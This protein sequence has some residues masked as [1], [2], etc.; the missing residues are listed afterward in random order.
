MHRGA[1][2]YAACQRA[3]RNQRRVCLGG[4]PERGGL[5]AAE[6]GPVSALIS[7]SVEETPSVNAGG[8]TRGWKPAGRCD[9]WGQRRWPAR[10]CVAL[11]HGAVIAHTTGERARRNQRCLRLDSVSE[12]SGLGAVEHGPVHTLISKVV[13]EPLSVNARFEL[14]RCCGRRKRGWR[15]PVYRGQ[16]RRPDCKS[17]C[18]VGL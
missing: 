1:D 14:G 16:P 6:H 18:S 10:R 2:A 11:K 17:V 9:S 12:R 5:T 7:K 3:R 13:D 4:V 8:G 15:R